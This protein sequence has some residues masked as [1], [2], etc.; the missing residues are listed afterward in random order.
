MATPSNLVRA[1]CK[2]SCIQWINTFNIININDFIWF[3]GV[4]FVV[5]D[6]YLSFWNRW[7]NI[8][9]CVFQDKP[10]EFASRNIRF[11]RSN[12]IIFIWCHFIC[13]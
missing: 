13:S 2:S 4:D 10:D 1:G 6:K 7:Y 8:S 12:G 11:F 5:K 3:I 9:Q